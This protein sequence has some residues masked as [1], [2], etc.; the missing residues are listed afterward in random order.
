LLL[1][2]P[3]A[4][5]DQP[6]LTQLIEEVSL[7]PNQLVRDDAS[8]GLFGLWHAAWTGSTIPDS[9]SKS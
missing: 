7:Q 6:H 4:E 5:L 3:A 8:A 1:D 2:D 9:K